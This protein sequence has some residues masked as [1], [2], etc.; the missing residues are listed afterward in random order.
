MR[1]IQSMLDMIRTMHGTASH[2][3]G[4]WL[5]TAACA[6]VMVSGCGS[7]QTRTFRSL[8]DFTDYVDSMPKGGTIDVSDEAFTA[9]VRR[10]V[11]LE[12]A[13]FERCVIEPLQRGFLEDE[14]F[15]LML[16]DTSVTSVSCSSSLPYYWRLTE[17][18]RI[19]WMNTD[20]RVRE[21]FVSTVATYRGIWRS[22]SNTRLRY[23]GLGG[24]ADQGF[25]A[26]NAARL[27]LGAGPVYSV[28]LIR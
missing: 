24:A 5:V 2:T 15:L 16:P 28:N 7:G 20:V 4:M 21:R 22:D 11:R 10:A 9:L 19:A 12:D 18:Q 3:I 13:D 8:D 23:H 26:V 17:P 14:H 25:K 1:T 6:A 27:S